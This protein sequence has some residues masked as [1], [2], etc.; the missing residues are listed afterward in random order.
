[1]I[2][3]KSIFTSRMING[4]KKDISKRILDMLAISKFL[5]AFITNKEGGILDWAKKR[6][7][8]EDE[9][10]SAVMEDLEQCRKLRRDT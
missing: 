7:I 2:T 6:G 10:I 3:S 1:M 5:F 8:S 4:Y 9:V